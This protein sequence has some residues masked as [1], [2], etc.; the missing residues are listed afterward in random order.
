MAEF[1]IEVATAESGMDRVR[2]ALEAALDQL[3]EAGTLADLLHH[4]WDGEVLRLSGPGA[5]GSIFC[6]DGHLC[7]QVKLRLPAILLR[8]QIEHYLREALVQVAARVN[9]A[10]SG[11]EPTG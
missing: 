1:Q 10:E 6:A 4:A 8:S 3:A 11:A 7:A 5:K 9:S 2:P